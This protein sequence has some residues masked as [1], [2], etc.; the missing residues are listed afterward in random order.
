MKRFV[1]VLLM[2]TLLAPGALQ[3]QGKSDSSKAAPAAPAKGKAAPAAK[4]PALQKE[5]KEAFDDWILACVQ[6]AD[7]KKSC[8]I[9]QTLSNSSRQMIGAISIG[10]DK[11]GK[12]IANLRTPL[13]FAVNEGLKLTIDTQSGVALPVRTCLSNGCLGIIAL[14]QKMVGQLKTATQL[15]V[16]MQSL[17]AKPVVIKFSPKGL[18]NALAQLLKESD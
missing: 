10:K 7:G 16:T 4:P 9:S 14:D 17:Q 18:P 5:W 3:A 2:G 8:A 13:G 15:G 6:G 1:L 11:D 12:F